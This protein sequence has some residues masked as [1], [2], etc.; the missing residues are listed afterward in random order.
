[1]LF[2]SGD[3][4]TKW[5]TVFLTCFL[6]FLSC[7]YTFAD[8]DK[9]RPYYDFGVFA[10][11]DG[12]YED[13]V[14]NFKKALSFNPDNPYYHH[15]LGKTYLNVKDYDPAAV[16]LKMA[17]GL[18]A[19]VS[20]LKY[21]LALL[22][23]KQSSYAE[24]AE[25]FAGIGE[26]DPNYVMAQY[27]TGISHFK[28]KEFDKALPYL[29]NAS[30]R[31]P[32]IKSN[33]YYYAGICYLKT[34]AYDQA[35][36][37]FGYVKEN[38]DSETLRSNAVKWLDASQSQKKALKR[39]RLYAK[40]GY[41]YDSNILLDPVDQD[42]PTD[43]DDYALVSYLS[44]KYDFVRKG[45]FTLGAGYSHYT[46]NYETLNDFDLVGSM[47][48]IYARYRFGSLKVSLSYLPSYYW[49][50]NN[51][52]LAIHQIRPEIL[53]NVN[54]A[55]KVRF[56]YAY[57]TKKYFQID[58][59]S[60]HANL[61][62]LD[63]YHAF[64]DRRVLLFAGGGGDTYAANNPD[65]DYSQ[66]KGRLGVNFL[67]PWEL[68]LRVMGKVTIKDYMNVDSL[69]GVERKDTRWEGSGSLSRKVYFDWL[70]AIFDYRYTRNDS[71]IIDA[72]DIQVFDYQ[73]EQIT[74]SLAASF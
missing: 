63:L 51:D 32:T 6:F 8:E 47:G 70:S 28:L 58:G 4:M 1:V 64:F 39:Y 66:Q 34:G 46:V 29:I 13:A 9:G 55:F 38:A 59:R 42:R 14:I 19:E 24:S 50:G 52:Y 69:Y 23:F 68:R 7:Q 3:E 65:Q 74:F 17:W 73:R 71:N 27:Y 2:K 40:L 61:V 41:Q 36:N 62:N 67:L 30:E 25:L 49:V 26:A 5:Q 44:G 72:N 54:D 11:E 53:W 43:E 57:D 10:F 56:N 18:D 20:G 21:D 12:D 31:S 33:G 16:H 45:A 60:G 48:D 37:K 22:N 15:F 35:I